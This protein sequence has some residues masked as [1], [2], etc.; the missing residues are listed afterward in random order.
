[1]TFQERENKITELLE[2]SKKIRN[3][4]G[5]EYT[6]GEDV[7]AVFSQSNDLGINELQTVG[8]LM[9]KHYKSIR[10]FIANGNTKSE[11]PIKARIADLINYLLILYSLIPDEKLSNISK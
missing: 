8:I 11:E 10:S 1:M 6:D 3:T 7:N 9:D 2:Y 4:K 5:I